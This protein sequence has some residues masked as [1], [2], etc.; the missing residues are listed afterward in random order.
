MDTQPK[1]SSGDGTGKTREDTVLEK[2]QELLDKL[3]T[4]YVEDT[5]VEQIG[6]LGG[7]SIPLNIFLYQEIQRLQAVIASVRNTLSVMMQA[8]RGEVVL[9]AALVDAINSIFDARV[10]KTWVSSASGA[11][12]SWLSPTLGLW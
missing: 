1:E 11:E 4:D 3:P 2:A 10:P 12:L 8:I 7:M 6:K 5:Y 9:T